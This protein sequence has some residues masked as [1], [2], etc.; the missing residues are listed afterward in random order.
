MAEFKGLSKADHEK[1]TRAARM[2]T[3]LTGEALDVRGI[4]IAA[5]ETDSPE[6]KA[7]RAE[8]ELRQQAEV[9][10]KREEA[11]QASRRLASG[12]RSDVQP[13][14]PGP[15]QPAMVTERAKEAGVTRKGEEPEMATTGGGK[16]R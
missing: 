16:K 10:R 8:E 1:L 14:H 2:Y 9:T 4:P 15:G 6:A 11:D 12:V 13:G 5:E 3:T 7:K